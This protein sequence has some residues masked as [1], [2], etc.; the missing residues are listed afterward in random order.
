MIDQNSI[1]INHKFNDDFNSH[2]IIN[3]KQVEHKGS[4]LHTVIE[5]TACILL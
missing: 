2:I 5:I 1:M 4:G 3:R